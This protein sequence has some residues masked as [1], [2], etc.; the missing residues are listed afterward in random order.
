MND[1]VLL[2][3]SVHQHSPGVDFSEIGLVKLASVLVHRQLTDSY[4]ILKFG[5]LEMSTL[6]ELELYLLGCYGNDYWSRS[7]EV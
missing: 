1:L 6:S 4:L 2:V 7:D 3:S 5:E